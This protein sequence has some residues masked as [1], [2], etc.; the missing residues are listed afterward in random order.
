MSDLF[1]VLEPL[2]PREEVFAHEYVVDLNATQAAARAGYRFPENGYRL[3]ERPRIAA[4]IERI[5]AQRLSRTGITQDTV[6]HE[7]SLLA[8]SS[9]DHYLVDD[10]GNVR[11]ADGAPEGAMRAVQTIK[12]R[13]NVRKDK[14][15][16]VTVTRDVEI[17][18]WDKPAP[19]K[20]MGR[21]VGLFPDRIE[22]TGKDGKPIEM[23]TKI[24]RVIVDA[25]EGA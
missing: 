4:A 2:E 22:H 21:H 24:E 16:A 10:D 9:I 17:K 20:L 8:Q 14:D 5:K 3:L 6:L 18:L 7:M 12:R 13:V 23:V 11:L 19:L 25:P 1:D 15:G